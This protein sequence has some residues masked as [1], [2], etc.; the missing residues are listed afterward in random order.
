MRGG[1]LGLPAELAPFVE[2]PFV[3]SARPDSALADRALRVTKV[4]PNS[5]PRVITAP[6]ATNHVTRSKTTPIAQ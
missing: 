1:G 4:C 3:S 6:I 2:S 5:A